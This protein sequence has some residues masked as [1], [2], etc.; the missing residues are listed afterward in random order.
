MRPAA[1]IPDSL[2]E[3]DQWVV[4]RYETRAGGSPTKVPYQADPNSSS[5]ASTTDPSTWAPYPLSQH[6]LSSNK[7]SGA[8]F[9][10]SASDPFCGIDIDDCLTD[11]GSP[12]P[13]A[14]PILERFADSYAEI[15]PSGK[16]VKI[17][18][19]AQLPSDSGVAFPLGDGRI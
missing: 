17:W 1:Q 7:Y 3:L 12:K 18:T 5:M 16:G 13:W 2:T 14:V 19:R 8:G 11:E 9:V 6:S 15:S 10:F 4:W